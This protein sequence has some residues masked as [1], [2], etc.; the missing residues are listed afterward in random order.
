[1]KTAYQIT[2]LRAGSVVGT[3]I[4]DSLE[5]EAA[6]KALDFLGVK[7]GVQPD[8]FTITEGTARPGRK[9]GTVVFTP[10]A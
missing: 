1:M 4:L 8:D 2:Y 5:G 7:C 3:T 6:D 9:K 10:N